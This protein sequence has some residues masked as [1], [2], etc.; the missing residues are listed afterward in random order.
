MHLT[1]SECPMVVNYYY[2]YNTPILG[3]AKIHYL[4]TQEM[5]W[6]ICSESELELATD[7]RNDLI[8]VA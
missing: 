7:R 5:V 1:S 4:H 3:V 8:T 6:I 2:I